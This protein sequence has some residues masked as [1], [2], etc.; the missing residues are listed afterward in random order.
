M[1]AITS[2]QR[3][4]SFPAKLTG[5]LSRNVDYSVRGGSELEVGI[6]EF[7]EDYPAHLEFGTRRILRRPYVEPTSD[8]FT[9]QLAV[10][11]VYYSRV[12]LSK[13]LGRR[14]VP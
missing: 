6:K 8:A 1:G 4:A 13:R 10:E 9:E 7:G 3:Q 5:K 12:S 2:R 14:F 11:L